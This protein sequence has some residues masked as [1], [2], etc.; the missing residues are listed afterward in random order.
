M[1]QWLEIELPEPAQMTRIE[2]NCPKPQTGR[3][4]RWDS[5]AKAWLVLGR[6]ESTADDAIAG[7]PCERQKI[8][9]FRVVIEKIDPA[10]H[11]A[12]IAEMTWGNGP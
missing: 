3:V 10:N 5:E 12:E 6:F 7:I 9:R 2:L 4:E 11:A 1:P 8:S